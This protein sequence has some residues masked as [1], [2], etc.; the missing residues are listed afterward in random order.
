MT[1]REMAGHVRAQLAVDLNCTQEDMAGEKDGLVFVEAAENPGRR[2]FPRR[3]HHFEMLTMGQSI[4]VSATPVLLERVRPQL[5]GLYRDDAFAVPFVYGHS[6]YYLPELP[7]RR[8][9]PKPEGFAFALAEREDIPA[10][11]ALEG[12]HNALG[13]DIHHPRPDVLATLAMREGRVVGVAG[14]S[15]DCGMMWQVGIDVLPECRG[16]GL[17]SYLVWELTREVLERGK[18]PYYGTASSNIA[19]QRVAHRAGYLP[20]WV[21]AY[22]GRFDDL[23]LLPTS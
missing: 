9:V 5:M 23:E 7:V 4:V 3:E 13:Y 15:A 10:L 11:Y 2:P 6:L 22:R 18:I 16:F 12:F 20:A 17:A 8:S 21:C 1:Q 14:A 19:S